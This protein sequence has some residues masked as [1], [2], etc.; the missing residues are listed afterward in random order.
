VGHRPEAP[1]DGFRFEDV[2][3]TVDGQPVLDGISTVTGCEGITVLAGPSGAG[4][5]TLLRLCNRLEV[6]TAGRVL[7]DGMDVAT[8]EP[9]ALRRRAGMVFQQP[10]TFGG[11][12]HDNL[13]VADPD[14]GHG[15][16]V[17]VLDRVGLGAE[18]LDRGAQELS[19]GEAQRMCLART[20]LT[21]PEILLMDE[22]TASLDPDSRLRIEALVRS[23]AE[24]GIPSVWVSHDLDQIGR[25]ADRTIVLEAGRIAGPEETE[26]YLRG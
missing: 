18:L 23:L 22:P 5:S 25:I 24:D 9:T 19:G 20:L 17:E 7:F 3:F 8:L 12:V 26:R 15:R 16:C 4:K 1:R 2:S 14:A 13:L 10:V 11:S 6:P 21:D